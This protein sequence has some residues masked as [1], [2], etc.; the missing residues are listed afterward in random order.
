MTFA[1]NP[2]TAD[3]P[4][5]SPKKNQVIPQSSPFPPQALNND[6][7]LNGVTPNWLDANQIAIYKHGRGFELGITVNKSSKRSG[8]DLNSG[9]VNCKSCALMAQSRCLLSLILL[10]TAHLP[11]P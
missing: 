5:C 2:V 10:E 3:P 1:I 4:F 6:R 11:L 8:R 7:S 9:S